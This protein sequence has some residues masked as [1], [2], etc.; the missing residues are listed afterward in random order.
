MSIQID[1]SNQ[2]HTL[3]TYKIDIYK[4]RKKRKCRPPDDHKGIISSFSS[5]S[6][7]E[8]CK[9]DVTELEY[10]AEVI[11]NYPAIQK[12]INRIVYIPGKKVP[13]LFN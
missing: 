10:L 11:Y 8:R 9:V 13:W 7:R 5:H 12:L 2:T 3:T 6:F 1:D 4:K